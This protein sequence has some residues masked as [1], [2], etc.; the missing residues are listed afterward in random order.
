MKRTNWKLE[1]GGLCALAFVGATSLTHAEQ[2]ENVTGSVQSVSPD[3]RSIVVQLANGSP[4]SCAYG[5]DAAFVDAAGNT[6]TGTPIKPAD[7]V[8]ISGTMEGGRL[9]V[10]KVVLTQVAPITQNNCRP[11]ISW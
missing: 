2:P 6:M 5:K 4:I 1:L 11:P 3:G 9:V 8:T 7:V 10:S